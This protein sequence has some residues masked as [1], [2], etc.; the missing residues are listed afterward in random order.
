MKQMP[1]RAQVYLIACYL[2]G[3]LALGWLLFDRATAITLGDWLLALGLGVVA[4]VCQVL[5]VARVGTAGQRSDHLTLS[6]LFAAALLLPNPLL[7]LVIIWTFIPEWYLRRRSWY[8][9]IF[10][11]ATYLLAAALVCL[12][13][14]YFTGEHRLMAATMSLPLVW[15]AIVLAMAV[16]EG[17]QVLMLAWVLKLARGQSFRTSGLFTS[18]SLLLEIALLCTGLGFAIAWLTAPVYGLLALVPLILIF[19][20]LHVPNLK[21]QAET[22][23]KTGLANMRRFNEVI[24]REFERAESGRQPLSILMCD[25]DYLRNI[26][27]SYG[28]HAGDT[29]LAGIADIIR[30]NTDAGD[31]AARFGG[32]EVVVLLP[33]TGG[34]GARQVAE[35]IRGELEQSRFDVGHFLGLVSPTVSIGVAS[36]PRDARAV[37]E[38]LR[39]ADLAVYQAK[40]E[41]RNRVVAAGHSSRE[42]AA[43]WSSEHLVAPATVAESLRP[44]EAERPFWNVINQVTRASA[45]RE[46]LAR[47][48][49]NASAARAGSSPAVQPAPMPAPQVLTLI[50]VILVTGLLGLLPGMPV[51]S[52]PWLPV[53]L[54]AGLTILAEQLAVENV[55]RGRISVSVVTILA[56]GFLNHE[57]GILVTALAAVLSM[58]VKARSLSHRTLFNL[59]W[60]LL[61]AEGAHWTFMLLVGHSISEVPVT[62]M[63]LAA[64]IAGLIYHVVNQVLLCLIRGMTEQRRAWEIWYS[65]YRWLWPHYA[66]LGALAAVLVLGYQAL[67]AIGA[68]ALMAPVVMM[69][70]AIKQY[71]DRT[72]VYVSEL[73]SMNDRLSESYEGTL[74]A[75]SRALDTRD[76]ETEAHSQRVAQYTRLIGRRLGVPEEEL[77]HIARGALLHDIGKI[78]VPDAVLLKP[79]KLSPEEHASMRNHPVIGYHMIASIPFLT[80]AAQVV[81]HHHEA[82]DGSGY[83]SGLS[84]RNIPLGARIFAVADAFDAMTTHRPYRRALSPA[85]ACAEIKR[86]SGGQFD[87]LVVD[88]FLSIPLAELMG[89]PEPAA[90]LVESPNNRAKPGFMMLSQS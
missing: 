22:D 43:E 90:P 49:A 71:L 29:V 82:Y 18:E 41:G 21:E 88:T 69:H 70:V 86:C 60:V 72:R 9:Q 10:N 56:A 1:R 14:E 51:D 50:G 45:N 83:P 64:A 30:R 13:L 87:P 31:L 57:L 61:A 7:A 53:L 85:A 77:E 23:P 6:P 34:E 58:A 17:T 73:R 35:R 47:S 55:G 76:D 39:E 40:R 89:A 44:S 27:N 20:A 28:H 65:E 48:N 19:Q 11:M 3:A 26:N 78:G 33:N 16:L 66:V 75:L 46:E 5:V 68:A 79:G 84:G 32:E 63:L 80:Q 4:S 42:L 24:A 54:F 12:V 81:L 67:G 25:L 36:F 38:L 74:Q 62:R 15:I 52:V 59:G 2:A 37:E 8:G